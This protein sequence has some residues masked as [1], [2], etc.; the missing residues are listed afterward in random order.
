MSTL[1]TPNFN[2]PNCEFLAHEL[3]NERGFSYLEWYDSLSGASEIAMKSE[4][5]PDGFLNIA[6]NVGSPDQLKLVMELFHK[7][8]SEHPYEENV[9]NM[10]IFFVQ[11]SQYKVNDWLECLEVLY[12]HLIAN[13]HSLVL[14]AMLMFIQEAGRDNLKNLG[15]KEALM[16]QMDSFD[17][18]D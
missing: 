7:H 5:D 3:V 15:L 11:D 1:V 17:F 13:K 12:K 14:K 9:Y 10:F 18:V 2:M 16:A 4:I 6:N 8:F